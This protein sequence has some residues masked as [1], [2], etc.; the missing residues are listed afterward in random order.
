M[1]GSDRHSVEAAP[2]VTEREWNDICLRD[3]TDDELDG[4]RL[5]KI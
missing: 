1:L 2:R 4:Y 5:I 3:M